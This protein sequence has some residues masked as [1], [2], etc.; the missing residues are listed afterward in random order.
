MHLVKFGLVLAGL[1][2]IYAF[3]P[4]AAMAAVGI[5]IWIGTK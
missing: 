5:F 2:V 4:I 3:C 1:A